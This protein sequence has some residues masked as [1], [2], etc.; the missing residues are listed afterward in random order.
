[1]TL[2][3]FGEVL[4]DAFSAARRKPLTYVGLIAVPLVV[5]LFGLLYVN[6][7]MDPYEKMK[8]SLLRW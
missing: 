1:M 4:R 3:A 5:A 8:D 7:F 2:K 6:V